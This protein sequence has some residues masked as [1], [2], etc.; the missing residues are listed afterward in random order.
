MLSVIDPR[1]P[2][3]CQNALSSL[4]FTLVPLPPFAHLPAPVCSHPDMLLFCIG[5]KLFCHKD[6]A[7]IAERQIQTILTKTDLELVLTDDPVSDVYPHDISLNLVFTRNMILGKQD[8]MAKKV[9][10]YAASHD[11]PIFSVKQGYTK[12]ASV[13]LD[14][15]VITSDVSIANVVQKAEIDCLLISHGNV[16]LKG[17]DYGFIGGASGVYQ[18][19]VFFCGDVKKHPDAKRI[20]CFCHSHGYEM[21]SL[22]CEPL[23]DAGTIMFF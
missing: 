16:A 22:S 20:E 2:M 23:F 4:G 11:I 3:P 6:Y 7:L 9:K 19:T 13:V 17:Y 14:N 10:Q 15:G 8:A 21:R 12:C 5:N 1:L 18:N